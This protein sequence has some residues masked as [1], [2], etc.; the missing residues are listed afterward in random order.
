MSFDD[1][2]GAVNNM[3]LEL[4]NLVLNCVLNFAQIPTPPRNNCPGLRTLGQIRRRLLPL[5]KLECLPCL[6]R[7]NGCTHKVLLAK[8]PLLN[9]L[10]VVGDNLAI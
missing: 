1:Y 10:W 5:F 4:L 6:Q 7:L 3:L 2:V 8:N 9:I